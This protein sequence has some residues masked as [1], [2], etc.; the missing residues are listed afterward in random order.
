MFCSYWNTLRTRYWAPESRP[1]HQ[2]A[3][4]LLHARVQP[5]LAR[6]PA[7]QRYLDYPIRWFQSPGQR[8]HAA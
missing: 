6:F 2:Q 5:L 4:A 3:W 1:Y 8:A 7:A